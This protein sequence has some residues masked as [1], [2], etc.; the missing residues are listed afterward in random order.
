M[1]QDEGADENLEGQNQLGDA[2]LISGGG[3]EH[4]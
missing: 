4:R 1:H 2:S 3:C